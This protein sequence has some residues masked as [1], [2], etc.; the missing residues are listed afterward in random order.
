MKEIDISCKLIY[1][2][3]NICHRVENAKAFV[4]HQ[5]VLDIPVKMCIQMLIFISGGIF[6]AK[7]IQIPAP[8]FYRDRKN[9]MV[10]LCVS[11]SRNFFCV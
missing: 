8:V 7:K 2:S 6:H 9:I 10:R 5:Q 1:D 4:T 3:C 11:H